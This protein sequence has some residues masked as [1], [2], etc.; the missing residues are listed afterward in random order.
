[1]GKQDKSKLFPRTYN[2][3]KEP[4]S[5]LKSGKCYK[6]ELWKQKGKSDHG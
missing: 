6:D 1:M 2:V 4:T 5:T 3:M